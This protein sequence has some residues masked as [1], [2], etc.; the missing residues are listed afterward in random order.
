MQTRL[1]NVGA[2]VASAIGLAII[3]CGNPPLPPTG[4]GAS[5]SVAA[6][7]L[8]LTQDAFNGFHI[9]V[10]DGWNLFTINGTVVVSRDATGTEE[11]V[12]HPALITA[13]VTPAALFATLLDVLKQQV[14]A[15]GGT[16]TP[17]ITG[18][19]TQTP[20]ATLTLMAG[21]TM[22]VGEAH[23]AVLNEPTAYGSSQG[24]LIAS[25]APPTQFSADKG[26]LA[27]IGACYGPQ[28][29]ALYQVMKDQVFT[30]SIPLGWTV[31]SETQDSIVIADGNDASASY[32]LTLLPPGSGVSSPQ[33]LLSYEFGQWGIQEGQVLSSVQLPNTQVSGGATQGQEYVEFDGTLKDGRAV[34]GLVYALSVTGSTSVSGVIR[35]ALAIKSLWNSVNGAL[36]HII[37]SIQ[38]DFTQDLRQWEHV[39]RQ[40]QAF[41]QQVQG[42]D[43]ALNG[44]DLVND[45][46]TGATFEAPYSAYNPTGPN[47]PGYYSQAGTKLTVQTP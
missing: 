2:V 13:G 41:D 28:P 31:T 15:Y 23:L 9:G 38:H 46:T 21:P 17:T 47:G 12:V 34:R 8:P 20:T 11:A 18:S 40:W 36:A 42:F 37:G 16:M 22:L 32:L 6:C 26:M 14:A 45:P 25:W 3:G 1:G 43:Y 35:M 10:P 29:G 30:Y 19:G 24:A 39:S 27:A 33:T 4:S 5:P 44:V 7:T